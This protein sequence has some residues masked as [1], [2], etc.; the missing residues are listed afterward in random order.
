MLSPWRGGL[1]LVVRVPCIVQATPSLMLGCIW[2]PYEPSTLALHAGLPQIGFVPQ[3]DSMLPT[4]T[5]EEC[6]RYS[7]ILRCASQALCSTQA[8]LALQHARAAGRTTV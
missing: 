8:C 3:D 4:L 2:L 5:V 6:I 7:A 1:C